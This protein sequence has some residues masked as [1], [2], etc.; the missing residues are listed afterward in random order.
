MEK[1]LG[2]VLRKR[3]EKGT[4]LPKCDCGDN[5]IRRIPPSIYTMMTL[6]PY[7][8]LHLSQLVWDIDS[9]FLMVPTV[10]AN[11]HQKVNCLPRHAIAAHWI[12]CNA[13]L[14]TNTT[15]I[16]MIK[17][18]LW[19][20]LCLGELWHWDGL[21]IFVQLSDL[22]CT[23]FRGYLGSWECKQGYKDSMLYLNVACTLGPLFTLWWWWTS[24]RFVH[25][26]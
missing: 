14:S 25:A 17:D 9:S 3:E 4:F 24:C 2:L 7:F 23:R 21:G 16:Y 12:L 11:P 26:L 13:Y 6:G 20:W 18:L 1:N 15:L 10:W 5:S 22:K 19:T 8:S